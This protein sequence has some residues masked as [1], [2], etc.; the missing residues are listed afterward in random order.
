MN[1][2]RLIAWLGAALAVAGLL[3][4]TG[5]AAPVEAAP[6]PL[7]WTAPTLADP[8]HGFASISCP[9]RTLCRAGDAGNRIERWNG[10]TWAHGRDLPPA[11]ADGIVSISC[12]SAT[13][14]AGVQLLHTTMIWDKEYRP[15]VRRAV[16]LVDRK[17]VV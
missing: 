9:G 2:R 17:S 4:A 6:T 13:F 16:L 12:T 14:C 15:I 11:A 10:T 1:R 8:P 5:R 7:T 3:V